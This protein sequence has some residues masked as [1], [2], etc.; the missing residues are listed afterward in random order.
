MIFFDTMDSFQNHLA[1][2]RVVKV[3]VTPSR[4]FFFAADRLSLNE[5]FFQPSQC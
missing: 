3:N 4:I 1:F 5:Y 2:P